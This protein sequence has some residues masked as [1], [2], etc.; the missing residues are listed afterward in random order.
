MYLQ[1]SWL[2]LIMRFFSYDDLD[3]I[4]DIC[5][6]QLNIVFGCIEWTRKLAMSRPVKPLVREPDSESTLYPLRHH[7]LL[8]NKWVEIVLKA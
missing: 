1:R 5:L 6:F 8:G 3:Y 2:Y 7:S 4:E